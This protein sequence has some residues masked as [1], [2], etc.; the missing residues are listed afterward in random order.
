MDEIRQDGKVI[1]QS[2]DGIS[3]PVIFNNLTG[4]NFTGREYHNYI[5]YVAIGSIGFSP[6]HIEHCRNGKVMDKGTI[7]HV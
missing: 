6:G 4:K 3:I 5:R 7:P 2:N 1:L